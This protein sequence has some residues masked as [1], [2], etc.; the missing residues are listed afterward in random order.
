MSDSILNNDRRVRW[1]Y[2]RY[3]SMIGNENI[4]NHCT[5]YLPESTVSSESMS[6]LIVEIGG[7]RPNKNEA[8]LDIFLNDMG[9]SGWE[10]ISVSETYEVVEKTHS[11]AIYFKRPV[12]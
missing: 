2:A 12:Q 5:L 8:G 3:V 10:M 11:M 6:G 1:E 4:L 9:S 7:R